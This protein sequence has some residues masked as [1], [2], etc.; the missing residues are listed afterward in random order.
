MI[1]TFEP[2]LAYVDEKGRAKFGDGW[3]Q[4]VSDAITSLEAA[5]PTLTDEGREPIDYSSLATQAAYVYA[6]A[7][8]R[9]AFTYEF[10][11]RHRAAIGKPLFG[12]NLLSVVSFGGGPGSE[13]LGLVQYLCDEAASESVTAIKYRVFDKDGKWSELAT[14]AAKIAHGKL[15]IEIEYIELDVSDQRAMQN[16]N[17]ADVDLVILSYIISELCALDSKDS[18]RDSMRST[19]ASLRP[20]SRIL[21]IESKHPT[22]IEYFRDCK[23]VRGLKQINDNGEPVDLELPVLTETYQKYL[24]MTGREPRMDGNIV[25]KLIARD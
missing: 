12:G 14:L 24:E 17:L 22:F 3:M 15:S 11:K 9:A 10:L 5:Y 1:D 8:P 16:I 20:G 23:L 21:F 4:M 13:L 6:Y 19:L 18:I 25:S 7:L 2:V